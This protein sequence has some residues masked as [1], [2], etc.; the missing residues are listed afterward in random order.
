[1]FISTSRSHQARV[2][3]KFTAKRKVAEENYLATEITERTE[4]NKHYLFDF[5]CV[6][7]ALCG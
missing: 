4:K 1:M 6:H 2:I 7:C 5:L 3:S